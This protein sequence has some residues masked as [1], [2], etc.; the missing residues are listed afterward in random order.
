LVFN[1]LNY[2]VKIITKYL[3]KLLV[4]SFGA[5]IFVS[6][7]TTKRK[8]TMTYAA[9]QTAKS[10]HEAAAKVLRFAKYQ[11]RVN[12][13]AACEQPYEITVKGITV[14]ESGELQTALQ[15]LVNYP[16]NIIAA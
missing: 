13:N 1:T 7:I 14:A 12:C 9:L 4:N 2:Y 15:T 16:V 11:A 3:I 5:L 8:R 6:S 10:A